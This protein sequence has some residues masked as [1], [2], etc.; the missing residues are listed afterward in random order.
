MPNGTGVYK[1]LVA[2]LASAI[3]SGAGVLLFASPKTAPLESRLAT[4]E[5]KTA[6]QESKTVNVEQRLT[7]IE[8]KLDQTIDLLTR[9]TR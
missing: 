3:L 1:M 8:A 7:R 4:Q 5:S 2:I 9:R 6:V